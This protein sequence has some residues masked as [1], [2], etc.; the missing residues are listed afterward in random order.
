MK[1]RKIISMLM[2]SIFLFASLT[3]GA[4]AKNSRQPLNIN[5]TVNQDGFVNLSMKF[6]DMNEAKWALKHVSKMFSKNIIIG[7]VDGSFGPNKPVTQAEAVVMTMRAAGFQQEI[8]SMVSES[9][10]LPFRNSHGVPQWAQK[11]VSLAY[12]KGF[13]ETPGSDKFQSNKSATREWFSVLIVK[14]FGWKDLALDKNDV[15]LPFKDQAE[16]DRD[17]VGYIAVAVEKNIITGMPDGNFQPNK[18]VTRAQA[19]VMLGLSSGEVPKPSKNKY[20]GIIS[21]KSVHED[22]NT[23]GSITLNMEKAGQMTFPVANDA[24]IYIGDS[25]AKLG[26]I[27]IGSK[28]EVIVNSDNVVVYL[29]IEPVTVKGIIESIDPENNKISIINNYIVAHD[30]QIILNGKEVTLADLKSGDSVKMILDEKNIVTFIKAVEFGKKELKNSDGKDDQQEDSKDIKNIIIKR[31]KTTKNLMKM[32][33]TNH[34]KLL[35]TKYC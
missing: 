31:V 6:K 13:L 4:Q 27:A 14:A 2:L 17:L 30:A 25:I 29:E 19:A 35:S 12:Q 8:D 11:A 32:K 10:Y 24:A 5:I 28:A 20:E 26:E 7:Y 34:N 22:V 1:I 21:G 9:V 16:I 15:L 3:S 23:Q 18:P 33:M